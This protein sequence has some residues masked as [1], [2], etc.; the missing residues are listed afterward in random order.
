[1]FRVWIEEEFSD[2]VPDSMGRVTALSNK[3]GSSVPKR[4]GDFRDVVISGDVGE[5]LQSGPSS[6]QPE[7]VEMVVEGE[8]FQVIN[9]ADIPCPSNVN[10]NH[11]IENGRGFKD[12][13]CFNVFVGTREESGKLKEDV[14]V[15]SFPRL[16]RMSGGEQSD[17]VV[18]KKKKPFNIV[19]DKHKQAQKS[20]SPGSNNRPKKRTRMDFDK[21]FDPVQF[22]AQPFVDPGSGG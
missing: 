11:N 4:N 1:M 21:P 9:E 22:H 17:K 19:K 5:K 15:P 13:G 3:V 8:R 2:W 10:R 14:E 6:S 16:V 7:D 20:S 12:G 18:V